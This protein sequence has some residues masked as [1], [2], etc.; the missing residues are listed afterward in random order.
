MLTLQAGVTPACTT[1]IEVPLT[2]IVAVRWVGKVL[3]AA[4]NGIWPAPPEAWP[5]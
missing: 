1:V 5:T 4:V 3:E 2:F